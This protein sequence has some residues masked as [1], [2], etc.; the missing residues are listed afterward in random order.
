[1]VAQQQ[2]STTS[3]EQ[4][5][6]IES[7]ST[8]SEE[9]VLQSQKASPSW[10]VALYMGTWI[11]SSNSTILFNK[12]LIDTA[13]F[14]YPPKAILLTAIHL[15]FASIVTQILARTTTMLDSRHELPN[16]WD[17]FL[18]TV[19]PIGIVSAGSLVCGN[20]VYLHLS[21][22]LIQML[23]AASPVTVLLV[24][25]MFGL[26]NP[27]MGRVAN[28]LVIV[29]GVAIASAGAVKF[30]F[31]GFFFQIFGLGFEA[32]RVVLIQIMLNS[33]GLKMDAMTGLYYYAP[34]VALLNLVSAAIIEL[35]H[36]DIADL[37]RVGFF[38]LLL[39]AAV[40]FTLNF[41]SMVLIGKTSGLVMSL[42][43]IFKNILLI[44]CSVIIWH[45]ALTPIQLLGYTITLH[46]L[47]YYSFGWENLKAGYYASKELVLHHGLAVD[48][49]IPAQFKRLFWI[50]LAN[51]SKAQCRFVQDLTEMVQEIV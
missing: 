19:L 5:P 33:K 3:Y 41:T 29:L 12:W 8:L 36:F 23:K 14:K 35:P 46:A 28:I 11:I 20:M 6:S 34:V 43:G 2:S 18:T 30:S 4:I 42:S 1:M 45:T 49:H 37:H 51:P 15:I 25:W 50:G 10:K 48:R 47:I 22:A 7:A 44:V 26:V 40:A 21:V 9:P 32:V 13:G 38:M 27:T 24:S 17:F 16:S 39:N 31:V